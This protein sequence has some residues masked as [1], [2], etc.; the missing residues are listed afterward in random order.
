MKK[1]NF[2]FFILIAVFIGAFMVRFYNFS[3]RVNFGPEQA[4]SLISAGDLISKKFT[5]LGIP[6]LQR[7]TSAGHQIFSGALFTYSL[8]PLL[9]LFRYQP[10]P[11]TAFFALLNIVSGLLLFFVA[12][13]LFGERVAIFSSVLFLF[14]NYMIYH[15]LFIWILNYL[16][17]VGILTIYWLYKFANKKRLIF[18]LLLG[19]ISGVGFGLEYL[20]LFT[21]ILVGIFLLVLAKEKLKN[22]LLFAAGFILGNLPLVIFDIKHNFYNLGTL[23]Q[24]LVDTFSHPSQ[25]AVSYYHFLQFWP[26]LALIAALVF[27]FLY[28]KNKVLTLLLLCFYVYLNLTSNTVS[29]TGA[30]GT[31][32]GLTYAKIAEA[33]WIIAQDKP[34]NFE[35]AELL[36]FDTRAYILRYPLEYIYDLKPMGV[37][38]YPSAKILYVLSRTDYDFQEPKVWE[39]SSLLPYKISLL[40]NLDNTYAVYKI[41]K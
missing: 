2:G 18:A 12:K 34:N 19:I 17:L 40:K 23:W 3:L 24:Y 35:V 28:K 41:T 11:I 16:P 25:G 36:D 38:D 1:I 13:K 14:N 20:Y 4:I 30:V 39:L 33:A 26:I 21:A 32:K 22:L 10:I 6:N 7:F 37:E 9:I 29:F 8:V 15:S 5:L 31:P 27:E